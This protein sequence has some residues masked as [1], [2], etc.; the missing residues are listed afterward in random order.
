MASNYDTA[1]QEILQKDADAS[2]LYFGTSFHPEAIIRTK[3]IY[4]YT[5]SGHRILDWTSGQMSCLIGHGHPEIVDVITNH[6]ANLDHLFSGM[7]SPP[8]ISLGKRLTSL[9]PPGLDKALFLS[10]GGESNEAA[11]RLAKFYTGKF[12]IV[13]LAASWHGMAGATI[14]AQYH[15]G[16][17]GYGPLV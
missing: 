8:V 14:G 2:L 1:D 11:I 13:G 17:A 9:T 10:T 4:M 5:A 15:S 7:L 16:R 12:E 6:A 3:G